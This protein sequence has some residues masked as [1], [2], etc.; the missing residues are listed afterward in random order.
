[1]RTEQA[2]IKAKTP[3]EAL[4]VIRAVTNVVPQAAIV[5]GS[6]VSALNDLID[7]HIF[8]YEEIFAI[9]PGVSGHAGTLMI[10]KLPE[11]KNITLAVFRGRYHVYEGHDWSVVTLIT[12]TIAQ[13]GI[14]EL[15]LTNASGGINPDFKV[16]DLMVM[17]GFRD[18]ISEKWRGGLI[19]AL[20]TFPRECRNN[21]SEKIFIAGARLAQLDKDFIP[22]KNGIYAGFIGPSYETLAEIGMVRKLGCDAVAMSTVP[23]LLTASELG[24]P[25]AAISV[26]TNIW[27]TSAS[28]H[29]HEDVLAAAK[30]AS[31]RLDKLFR[32]IYSTC[33]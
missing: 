27:N 12:N 33:K 23:E 13:W 6:G 11:N 1:M 28:L 17:T 21:L 3:A 4:A 26:I 16:G 7:S 20:K 10:G 14:N 5:L 2:S 8:S 25:T 31:N 18:L 15:I 9:A 24:L 30:K 22:L 29:G 32:Q 19:E